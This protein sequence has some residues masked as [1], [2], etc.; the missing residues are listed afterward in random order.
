MVAPI[1]SAGKA[2]VFARVCVCVCVCAGVCV[3]VSGWGF[4]VF[5]GFRHSCCCILSCIDEF[6]S[7]SHN[8]SELTSCIL[9]G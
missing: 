5:L 1:M 2:D 3:R 6:G 8:V 4:V 9:A 7:L